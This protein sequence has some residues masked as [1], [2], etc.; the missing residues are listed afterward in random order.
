MRVTL[1]SVARASMRSAFGAGG[2]YAWRESVASARARSS[3]PSTTAGTESFME[4]SANSSMTECATVASSREG[5]R[6]TRLSCAC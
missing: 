6:N 2:K 4:S 5:T 1:C 3:P